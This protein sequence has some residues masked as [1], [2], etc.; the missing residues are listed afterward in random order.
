MAAQ[1]KKITPQIL[2]RIFD[3]IA[4]ENKAGTLLVSDGIN[5]KCLY[6]TMTGLRMISA[7]NRKTGKIGQMLIAMEAINEEILEEALSKQQKEGEQKKKKKTL[8]GEILEESQKVA[9]QEV[10]AAVRKQAENEI[11]D[12]YFW[13][14]GVYEFDE[15]PAPAKFYDER[16]DSVV[17]NVTLRDFIEAIRQKI[18]DFRKVTHPVKNIWNSFE[19]TSSGRER[20]ESGAL[21]EHKHRELLKRIDG[22]KTVAQ[23]SY[24]TVYSLFEITK[25]LSDLLTEGLVN[26]IA[27]PPAA[28]VDFAVAIKSKSKNEIEKNMDDLAAAIDRAINDVLVHRRL[29]Q[30]NEAINKPNEAAH[31]YRQV[32]DIQFKKENFDDSL[33][34]FDKAKKMDPTDF[35]SQ[36]KM[37]KIYEYKKLDEKM[38]EIGLELGKRFLDNGLFNKAKQLYLSLSS[39][40]PENLEI[41]K[42]L[43]NSYVGLGDKENAKKEME[44][45]GAALKKEGKQEEYLQLLQRMV[46]FQM[47][48]HSI[49]KALNSAIGRQL[50]W[51]VTMMV[52][53]VGTVLLI[54]LAYY[55]FNEY[56]SVAEYN[57]A[58]VRTQD[59]LYK[60]DYPGALAIL[61]QWY[62]E[63]PAS[64]ATGAANA[65]AQEIQA[66]QHSYQLNNL[67][68]KKAKAELET[69]PRERQK[70]FQQ[71]IS[72]PLWKET[73]DTKLITEREDLKRNLEALGEYVL[74]FEKLLAHAESLRSTSPLECYELIHRILDNYADFP[75]IKTIK[76]PFRIFSNPAGASIFLDQLPPIEL[77][78]TKAL[79]E[80]SL[81]LQLSIQETLLLTAK[82]PG[83]ESV[84]FYIDRNSPHEILIPFNKEPHWT[85]QTQGNITTPITECYG[86]LYFTA[87]DGILYALN[88]NNGR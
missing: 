44:Q 23:L 8:L 39:K 42:Q 68:Y 25:V 57:T 1:E 27:K 30:S 48:D 35:S 28:V 36:Q 71:L 46:D 61:E 41:R 2:D 65:L 78:T 20:L 69:N 7:G 85:F 79:P 74:R 32:G 15:G 81:I 17:L 45:I 80:N 88:G 82:L 4:K 59:L 37:M 63:Y 77:G 43:L 56:R 26:M 31:H 21:N 87:S 67:Q 86:M 83:F 84:A 64:S 22:E 51:M 58:L 19:L 49:R 3:K 54:L 62:T 33:E 24:G 72:D 73:K 76:V 38:I 29:A 47:A 66:R 52:S 6:F 50:M 11:I 12:L 60:H 55:Y 70:L 18:N 34:A 53:L 16:F 40:K 10:T 5:E 9:H 13:A 14:E 75:E